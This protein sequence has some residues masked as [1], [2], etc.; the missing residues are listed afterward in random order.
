MNPIRYLIYSIAITI[1][2]T[3]G[4]VADPTSEPDPFADHSL[5]EPALVKGEFFTAAGLTV[6]PLVGWNPQFVAREDWPDVT[7]PT[8]FNRS[9]EAPTAVWRIDGGFLAS[10]NAGEFGGALFFLPHG[11][12]RWSK[13][14]DAH[15]SHL[16]R[17]EGD[18]YLAVGGL[19]HLQTTEGRAFLI[20]R[21]NTGKW[22]TKIAF[23]TQV[24]VPLILGTTFTDAFLEAKAEKLIVIGLDSNWGWNPLFGI[25]R[26]GAVHYL[27]ERLKDKESEQ[28]GTGQPATRPES[29][30][31][32]SDKPQP[33]SEGRSR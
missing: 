2:A 33:E 15:V 24:G 5:D 11:A 26:Q 18:S 13:I 21:S 27:G 14:V 12:K 29:K 32:G 1:C 9:F 16:E 7:A 31:E 23:E 28:D 17:F 6:K 20:T 25:S 30:S 10:F 22:N 3:I 4:G 8:T 19:A